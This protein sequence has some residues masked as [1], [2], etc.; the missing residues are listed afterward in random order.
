MEEIR[1]SKKIKLC[2]YECKEC[3]KEIINRQ[4]SKF[5]S[6]ECGLSFGK[7][8]F[9][10]K[11]FKVLKD[12]SN[13]LLDEK[14]KDIEKE[15]KLI[16]EE[17]NTGIRKRIALIGNSVKYSN[18][19]NGICGFDSRLLQIMD[20]NCISNTK[21]LELQLSDGGGG[22]ETF[23]CQEERAKCHHNTRTKMPSRSSLTNILPHTSIPK[24]AHQQVYMLD[25][26]LEQ[27]NSRVQQLQNELERIKSLLDSFHLGVLSQ[28]NVTLP[29]QQAVIVLSNAGS[30][31]KCLTM[32]IFSQH[33]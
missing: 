29:Y 32:S 19:C 8:K 26:Q 14:V 3:K 21:G 2:N 17:E 15:I 9:E 6:D 7:K 30:E 16:L 5:C 13:I 10:E 24:W 11:K 28:W 25:I 23:I 20:H 27:N 4:T 12:P 33:K 31:R 1:N 18:N 22:N